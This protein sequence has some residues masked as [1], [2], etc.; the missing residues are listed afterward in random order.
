MQSA[1]IASPGST[2]SMSPGTRVFSST[3]TSS[4][5]KPSRRLRTRTSVDT[6]D[7]S[8]I[9][10][11]VPRCSCQKRTAQEMMIMMMSRMKVLQA[12]G[13]VATEMI[14]S[15][16]RRILKGF[17][18]IA[19][20]SCHQLGGFLTDR[21]LGPLSARRENASS[22]VNPSYVDCRCPSAASGDKVAYACKTASGDAAGGTGVLRQ[23]FVIPTVPRSAEERAS[24]SQNTYRGQALMNQY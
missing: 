22:L 2:K 13:G 3:T 14:A 19:R 9:A 24:L 11:A 8:L 20:S 16:Q 7:W 10:A 17:G 5:R 23:S 1:G 6:F 15:K 18:M 4:L 12:G 21:R